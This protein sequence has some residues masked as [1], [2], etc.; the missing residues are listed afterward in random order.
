MPALENKATL[1]I[2]NDT[3]TIESIFGHDGNVVLGTLDAAQYPDADHPFTT[4]PTFLPSDPWHEW[5]ILN[6]LAGQCFSVDASAPHGLVLQ[7]RDAEGDWT[8][9]ASSSPL[10]GTVNSDGPG[11][12]ANA[13]G[14]RIGVAGD[15]FQ[16]NYGLGVD[17]GLLANLSDADYF[18][19]TDPPAGG[20]FSTE[21]ASADFDPLLGWFNDGGELVGSDDVGGN[22]NLSRSTGIVAE[23]GEVHLAVAGAGDSGSNGDHGESGA[24]ELSFTTTA[25]LFPIV[26]ENAPSGTFIVFAGL[27]SRRAV[28]YELNNDADGRFDIDAQTGLITVEDGTKLD[29]ETSVSHD[30]DVT[31]TYVDGTTSP[32]VDTLTIFVRDVNEAPTAIFLDNASVEENAGGAVV[33]LLTTED[34][35]IGDSHVYLSSDVRFEVVGGQLKLKDGVSLDHESEPG[36]PLT[37]T[38]IDEG[39]LSVEQ[40]FI[41]SV[42]DVNEA[43]IAVDDTGGTTENAPVSIDVLANDTDADAG[44]DPTTFSLDSVSIASVTGLVGGGTG[45]VSIGGNQLRFDPGADFDELDEGDTATVVVHYTMSDDGGASATAQATLTVT[46]VNDAPVVTDVTA[47]AAEDGPAVTGFFLGDDADGDDDGATLTYTIASLPGEGTVVDI[48]DATFT[49]DPGSD[50][51]ILAAGE[52]RDVTFGYT[53]TDSHGAVSNIGTV[54][55]TVTGANDA[56]VVADMTLAA[57]EDGPAIIAPFAGADADADDDAATLT[58]AIT[59]S[60]SEGGVINNGDSTFTF[61]PGA[62]FQDLAVGETRD[63]SFGYTATDSHGAVSNSGTVTVTVT[64]VNDAPVVEDVTAAAAED[65][66]AVTAS[67]VGDDVDSD[68][69][70]AT[71]TYAIASSPG[72]GD[73]IDNEDGT[74]TFDPGAGFQDLAM[75]GTRDV[76]FDY[77]A[78]DSHGAVSNIGTVTIT[79]TGVNDAPAVEDVTAAAAEDGPAVTASFAGD[80]VDSD[81]DGATLTYTITSSPSEGGAVNNGDGTF[82]F[83]PGASFQD[84]AEGETR[85]VAFDYAA[86]DSHGAVSNTGT[87]TITVSGQNDA[88]MDLQLSN[89]RV[90]ENASNGTIVGTVWATDPDTVDGFQYALTDTASGAFDIDPVTGRLTVDNASMLDFEDPLFEGTYTVEVMVTDQ[91]NDSYTEQLDI[92]LTDV[93]EAP[94]G[95][96]PAGGELVADAGNGTVVATLTTIDPDTTDWSPVPETFT[97]ALLDNARGRFTLDGNDIIV[98]DGGRINEGDSYDLLVRS[99]DKGG[100]STDQVMTITA[101][102]P[103][104]ALF[105]LSAQADW[106]DHPEAGDIIDLSTYEFDDSQTAGDDFLI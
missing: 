1:A 69:G 37:I 33:G 30:V 20:A 32:T 13:I 21:S 11:G 53:A 91:S 62:G 61:D 78:I 42:A 57:A 35:D 19:F 66:A 52:T 45:I 3:F 56:P 39:G 96:E 47:A 84:L 54:T 34:Q 70:G 51:Q 82:T 65:G 40:S 75:A 28:A 8:G 106:V 7:Q 76:A 79:V 68:D 41:L 92:F 101:S 93:N 4:D 60:P 49:F 12:Y 29:Y 64:G 83:D 85:D 18:T 80:D 46:G 88:P 73:M 2:P 10:E 24:Y 72:E 77:A 95:I 89:N 59:S 38:A 22:G 98:A 27:A 99:T 31:T 97:Y 23:S 105:V 48:D 6:Q 5:T 15:D 14:L 25:T 44:D 90:S 87:V 63:A 100:L 16:G 55:I 81:D 104:P 43:P 58:Y 36:V 67:F 74:F 9:E 26:F 86:T 103:P 102:P 71:L 50:F 94:T 17:Y